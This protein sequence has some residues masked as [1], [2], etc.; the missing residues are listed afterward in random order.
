[1]KREIQACW[2][3][4]NSLSIILLPFFRKPILEI[5]INGVYFFCIVF[6]S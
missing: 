4:A 5:K 6:Q 3:R 1:M 2:G